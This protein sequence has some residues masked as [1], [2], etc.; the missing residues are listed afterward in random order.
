MPS[1]CRKTNNCNVYRS[2]LA[3]VVLSMKKKGPVTIIM[4]YAAWHTNFQGIPHMIVNLMWWF[5]SPDVTVVPV[6]VMH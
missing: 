5:F 1:V 4:H 6:Y 3:M 2:L